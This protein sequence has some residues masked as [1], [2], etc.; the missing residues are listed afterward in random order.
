MLLWSN[1]LRHSKSFIKWTIIKNLNLEF[2]DL[3]VYILWR[4]G[5]K[6]QERLQMFIRLSLWSCWAAW[7]NQLVRLDRIYVKINILL[8][9]I[10]KCAKQG[11]KNQFSWILWFWNALITIACVRRWNYI[12]GYIIWLSGWME[13]ESCHFCERVEELADPGSDPDGPRPEACLW[14]SEH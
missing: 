10:C 3:K 7:F 1:M 9:V 11:G 8:H 13:R 4:G 6:T 12:S 5:L 2:S 14:S